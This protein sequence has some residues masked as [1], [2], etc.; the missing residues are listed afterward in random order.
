MIEAFFL[1][2]FWK[3]GFKGVGNAHHFF[4]FYLFSHIF[5]FFVF[6][7]SYLHLLLILLLLHHLLAVVEFYLKEQKKSK[8]CGK[9]QVLDPAAATHCALG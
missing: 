4:I 8:Q 9:K 1:E 2:L 7:I 5:S 6:F 3:G